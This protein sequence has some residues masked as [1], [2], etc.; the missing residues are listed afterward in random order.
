MLTG[1]LL[2]CT[3]LVVQPGPDAKPV[4]EPDASPPNVVL[5]LA[6]DQGWADVGVY[7]AEGFKTPHLDA[8]A[9]RGVRFSQFY[10]SQAVCSASRASVLTGCYSNRVGVYGAYY[11]GSRDGLHPEEQTLG[12]LLQDAGYATTAIGKWHLGHALPGMMPTA[13]GFDEYWGLL[14]SNDMWPVWYDGKPATNWKADRYKRLE[15]YDGVEVID[16]VDTLE[17]QGDLTRGATERAVDFIERKAGDSPFFVYV[18][19]SMPHVPLGVS[20]RWAGTAEQGRYGEVIQEIDW[21]VG[22]VLAALKRTGELDNTLVIYTSDNGPW[23]NYGTHAG[24]AGPLREGKGTMF[25]GGA[26]VPCIM[27][28]PGRIPEGVVLDQV[29]ATIDLVPT[30]AELTGAALPDRPIDGVSLAGLITGESDDGPRDEFAYYYGRQLQAVRKG[31]WKLH[32]PHR[33]RTYVGKTPGEDGFPGPTGTG[34]VSY[35]LF[36]LADDPGERRN[37]ADLHPAIVEDLKALAESYRERLGDGERAGSEQRPAGWAP[38]AD[39]D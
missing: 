17:D 38:D 20:E 8:L 32:L 11:P 9:A 35:D 15:L 10:V 31:N 1:S 37:V 16:Y 3:L 19:Y 30:I 2:A 33:H 6:D 22:E 21:S 12:E 28:W 4:A 36:N 34:R 14:Y 29:G 24:S 27:A 39:E 13:Q 25:E 26:R 5:F 18:P 23:M 7:G